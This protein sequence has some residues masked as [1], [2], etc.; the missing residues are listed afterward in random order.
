MARHSHEARRACLHLTSLTRRMVG[1]SECC[2]RS[3]AH[4]REVGRRDVVATPG[5]VSRAARTAALRS[6]SAS[7][8][9]RTSRSSVSTKLD[10]PSTAVARTSTTSAAQR[11]GQGHDHVGGGPRAGL[12]GRRTPAAGRGWARRAGGRAPCGRR[13]RWRRPAATPPA[14]G[15]GEHR[16]ALG[17]RDRRAVCGQP[18]PTSTTRP[19]AG[20][21]TRP[22]T[23]SPSSQSSGS[24]ARRPRRAHGRR[25]GR[26]PRRRPRRRARRAPASST[27]SQTS[28]ATSTSARDDDQ[29][30]GA[31]G[32]AADG[33]GAP[34]GRLGAP[35]DPAAAPD[36]R[37]PATAAARRRALLASAPSARAV[38]RARSPRPGPSPAGAADPGVRPSGRRSPPG[39]SLG[40]TPGRPGRLAALQL[41]AGSRGRGR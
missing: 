32:G 39:R 2:S 40:G 20:C 15:D 1:S 23:A 9:Q 30:A 26:V 24:P 5:R 33:T 7:A 14:C 10:R 19:G 25:P 27:V 16:L 29:P 13:S 3:S 8:P 17:H 12:V 35:G 18:R 36:G 31:G 37:A 41:G 34:G 11:R 4:H 38:R 28:S 6:L 21:A 22:A